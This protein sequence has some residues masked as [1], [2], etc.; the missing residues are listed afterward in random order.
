MH[1]GNP[2]HK[3]NTH[4][5]ILE[6]LA[7][8]EARAGTARARAAVTAMGK[9]KGRA[10]AAGLLGTGTK[11]VAATSSSS[12]TAAMAAAAAATSRTTVAVARSS[13]STSS[14]SSIND[15]T[16]NTSND[17]TEREERLLD[18]SPK[19]AEQTLHP[20]KQWF[21]QLAAG[22]ESMQNASNTT[23]PIAASEKP[24]QAAAPTAAV[25]SPQELREF[26]LVL[27][28]LFSMD[29]AGGTQ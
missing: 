18:Y 19:A 22:S 11:A 29:A 15:D 17:N 7:E 2:V 13:T 27:F 28:E 23:D 24:L 20:D 14:T 6:F 5:A 25:V 9:A 10:A 12:K 1:N 4:A 26:S 3:G 8:A 16:K 21:L